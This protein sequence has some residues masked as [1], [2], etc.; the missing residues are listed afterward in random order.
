MARAHRYDAP[1][2][3]EDGVLSMEEYLSMQ[4]AIGDET[5][6]RIVAELLREGDLSAT[7]LADAMDEPSNRL[8]YHLDALQEVGLV[9]NRKRKDRGADGLYSYYRATAMAEAIMK[10]GV[11]ELLRREREFLERYA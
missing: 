6:Y 5:R 4:R 2:L 10:H 9:Q 7:E 11:A 8:H 1:D 3:P